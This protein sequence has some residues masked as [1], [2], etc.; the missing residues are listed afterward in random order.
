M[1]SE[2]LPVV[3][4]ADCLATR[5]RPIKENIPK[6]LIE[7]DRR[8]FLEHQVELLRRN[9]INEV[10]LCVGYLGEMIEER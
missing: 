6:A 9:S 7:V 2:A 3:I 8:A 5:L 4:L 10:I 1:D